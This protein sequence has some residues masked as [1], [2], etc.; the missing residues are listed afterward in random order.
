M[1]DFGWSL[2]YTRPIHSPTLRVNVPLLVADDVKAIE[3]LVAL[4]ADGYILAII[5]GKLVV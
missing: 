5:L 2:N 4:Q 1:L 3:L